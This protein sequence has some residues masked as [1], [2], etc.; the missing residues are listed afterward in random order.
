MADA[1]IAQQAE[2]LAANALDIEAAKEKK[3]VEVKN[4]FEEVGRAA[5]AT[6]K[7]TATKKD[8]SR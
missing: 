8:K 1:L 3:T 6:R 2:I 7:N 5:S 4:P